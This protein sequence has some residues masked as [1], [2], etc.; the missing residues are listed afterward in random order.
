M[1]VFFRVFQ[2]ALSFFFLTTLEVDKDNEKKTK[3]QE[4]LIDVPF[5]LHVLQR[6][7]KRLYFA[8]SFVP[9]LK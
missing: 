7:R 9:Y 2:E 3:K 1:H 5:R 8:C 4:K 6:M